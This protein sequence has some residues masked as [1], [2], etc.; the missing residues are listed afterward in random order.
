VTAAKQLR[1]AAATFA[2]VV[3]LAS[4]ADT[5]WL[6][7]ADRAVLEQFQ[8]HRSRTGTAV[9]RAL[10]SLGEPGL[11][12]PAVAVAGMAACCRREGWRQAFGPYLVVVTGA[13]VRRSLSEVVARPRPPQDAWLAVPEGFSLPSRHTTLA[14]LAAGACAQ[15]LGGNSAMA[16]AAPI[17]AAAGVGAG[18]VY[19]GVHWPSDVLAGWLFAQGWLCLAG[20]L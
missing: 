3:A 11:I 9:A 1:C 17:L 20:S 19:L 6:A 16:Q 13:A 14:A 15:A 5:N 10:S 12:F 7:V 4:A 8:A 2:A 18:R